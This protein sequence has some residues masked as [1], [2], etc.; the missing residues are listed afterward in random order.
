M[1]P[2]ISAL[3]A[4]VAGGRTGEDAA[5]AVYDWVTANIRYIAVY[6]DPNDGWVP[7]QAQ[8]VLDH[9]YGDCKD[10]VVLMQ[11]MLGSLGIRAE[12]A[13]IDWGDRTT[14]APLWVPQFN[15]AIVYLPAFQR[16]LNPTDPYARYGTLMCASPASRGPRPP[17]RGRSGIR[18]RGGRRTTSIGWTAG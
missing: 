14:E 16:Y 11:A 3:A 10:H 12:A 6:L 2:A 8:T 9:G 15:H 17:R 7:H 5:R 4:Q 18:Q 1:T 13:M